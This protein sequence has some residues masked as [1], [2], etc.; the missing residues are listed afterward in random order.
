MKHLI[1][2]IK[3]CLSM[4][5][6]LTISIFSLTACSKKEDTTETTSTP[7]ATISDTTTL[8]PV[9]EEIT[10]KDETEEDCSES[11]QTPVSIESGIYT[12]ANSNLT[13]ANIYYESAS[14]L[15]E[16]FDT[17]G[18][19]GVGA[20]VKDLGFYE[21]AKN[22]TCHTVSDTN[23]NKAVGIV[24]TEN[25]LTLTHYYF[26]AA[27]T[28]SQLG[29]SIT[30]SI[31]D[32]IVEKQENQPIVTINE[33][34]N[35][36]SILYPFSYT[37]SNT[38]EIVYSP[39]FVQ[40]DLSKFN[41]YSI[42]S[43]ETKKY[44]YVEN[45]AKLESSNTFVNK[46]NCILALAKIFST[47]KDSVLSTISNMVLNFTTDNLLFINTNETTTMFTEKVDG[48][49]TY[50]VYDDLTLV[51]SNEIYDFESNS[52]IIN[53]SIK[54]SETDTFKCEFENK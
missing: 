52:S 29:D 49:T 6:V 3:I 12:F 16:H 36:V 48:Q 5:L 28:I 2:K 7:S 33:K 46:E 15:T 20:I 22:T 11:S 51:V 40:A 53:V 26:T 1:S 50:I 31:V 18:I 35:S 44:V 9:A 30:Y 4:V 43:Q 34:T 39:L 24:K 14:N 10:D 45:S 13:F 27:N 37:D 42:N 21:F 47:D 17:N 41:N 38:D 8:P 54:L 32:G 19:N 25:S 23:Y